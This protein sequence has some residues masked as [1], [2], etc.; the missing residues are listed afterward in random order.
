MLRPQKNSDSE[1]S[2]NKKGI[3]SLPDAFEN[4]PGF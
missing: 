2:K 3:R 4:K 1:R